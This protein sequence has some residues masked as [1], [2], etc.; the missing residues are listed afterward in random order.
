MN[1]VNVLALE[2]HN[3]SR[4]ILNQCSIDFMYICMYVFVLSCSICVVGV[5]RH[6]SNISNIH[7]VMLCMRKRWNN[8][9]SESM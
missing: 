9:T 1:R 3:V 2:C 5:E 4:D 7:L 6:I 8:E